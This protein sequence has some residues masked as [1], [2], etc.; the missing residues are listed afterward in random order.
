MGRRGRERRKYDLLSRNGKLR[1]ETQG[2][3]M[4]SLQPDCDMVYRWFD[5]NV[6]RKSTDDV[7]T[8]R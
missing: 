8:K 3:I 6:Y 1:P 7:T 2:Q 4:K 5:V